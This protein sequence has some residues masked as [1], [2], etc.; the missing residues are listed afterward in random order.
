MLVVPAV[1]KTVTGIRFIKLVL[2]VY[3]LRGKVQS[4]YASNGRGSKPDLHREKVHLK[5]INLLAEEVL[6][7]LCYIFF[8]SLSASIIQLKYIITHSSFVNF[9]GQW[10]L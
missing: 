6:I 3:H 8:N 5:L 10:N 7:L 2:I 1:N 4:L 9:A